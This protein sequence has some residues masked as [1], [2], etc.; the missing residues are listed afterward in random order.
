MSQSS[1]EKTKYTI[2]TSLTL[3][4]GRC[5]T[6]TIADD[7]LNDKI[8][9]IRINSSNNLVAYAHEPGFE[10]WSHAGMYP[11]KPNM[12]TIGNNVD[13]MIEFVIK[14]SVHI[15]ADNCIDDFGYSRYQC[16]VEEYKKGQSKLSMNCITPWTH[17]I[18][19]GKNIQNSKSCNDSEFEREFQYITSFFEMAR[20]NN[21]SACYGNQV[22]ALQKLLKS[23]FYYYKLSRASIQVTYS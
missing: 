7:F 5:Y 4:H 9:E 8:L 1:D 23:K 17:S 15:K 6:I 14:K 22:L 13:G 3:Y 12:V 19:D 11:E 18:W 21:M 10:I 20:R 2:K 16:L